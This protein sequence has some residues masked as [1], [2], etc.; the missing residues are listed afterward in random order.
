MEIPQ[1]Q[2]T[3]IYLEVP[4]LMDIKLFSTF[5]S[6]IQENK[7]VFNKYSV[8]CFFVDLAYILRMEVLCHKELRI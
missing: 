2:N 8:T 5:L 7:K 6:F 1:Y 4:L 3:W